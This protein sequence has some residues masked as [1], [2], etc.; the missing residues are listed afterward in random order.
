MKIALAQMD[1]FLGNPKKNFEKVQQFVIQAAE[2]KADLV[3][4]PEMWNTGYALS[5]LTTIADVDGRLTQ[6]KLSKWA[7]E[8]QISIVAGSVATQTSGKFYNCSYSFDASGNLVSTYNK[9][10]LFGPMNEEKFIQSGT[11]ENVFELNGILSSA[12]ICYDLRFPEWIRTNMAKGPE[13]LYV[14]AQWPKER[15]EQWKILL[16]ARAIENQA[17]V[18]AVNRVGKDQ[19]NQFDG[20]SLVVNPLGKIILACGVN[21]GLQ[22]VDIDPS[23]VMCVRG[24]IPVFEDRRVELYH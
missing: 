16:Q 20:H 3:V 8:N 5:A 12:V 18:V 15:I 2:K 10:H 14:V 11:K 21:E 19:N 7:K 24:Q 1:V 6:E 22:L 9:V 23:E 4:F 17:F 13:I